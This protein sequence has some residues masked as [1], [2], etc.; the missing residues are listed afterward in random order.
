MANND[1]ANLSLLAVD[2]AARGAVRNDR[3]T[4]CQRFTR[5]IPRKLP[6]FVLGFFEF[7]VNLC[8]T[9]LFALKFYN[10]H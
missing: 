6:I 8:V 4:C 3:S 2:D 9:L 5:R 7:L 10:V 1:P